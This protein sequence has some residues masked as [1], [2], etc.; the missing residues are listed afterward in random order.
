MRLLLAVSV[1]ASLSTLLLWPAAHAWALLAWVAWAPIFVFALRY[2]T[3]SW[4]RINAARGLSYCLK[5]PFSTHLGSVELDASSIA[6]L[7]LESTLLSR[8]LGLWSLRI[9]SRDGTLHPT[10]RF[11]PGMDR[12]ADELHRYL[13]Q[14]RGGEV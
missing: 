7:R 3:G 11:F 13:E 14:G 12:V 10:F 1:F 4:I 6:E 8:L 5:T 9:I 2:V